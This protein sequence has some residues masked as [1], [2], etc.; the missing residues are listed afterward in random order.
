[1]VQSK[2]RLTKAGDYNLETAE[3]LSYKITG[4][5]P[6]QQQPYRVDI[7]N[8]ILA[9]ELQEG[10]FNH[11]MLG[12]LQVYDTKDVRTLLPIVG[13]ERLN[14]KFSTPG[15]S[16]INATANEGHPFHIYKI[17]SVAPDVKTV[18]SG[19]QVYDIFFCSR[20]SYFN[21]LRKVSK[22]YEGPVEIGVEDI[23]VNKKYLN[24]RKDLYVEP[25]KYLT[26]M[27]MPNVRPFKAIEMLAKKAVS[28]KYQNGGYLFYETKEGYQFRSI[29]SLLAVGGAIA[30]PAKWAYRYQQ[31]N[32]RHHSGVKDIVE[33]MHGVLSWNLIK[34][35]NT[36]NHIEKGGYASKLIE[37][38]MFNKTITETAYD[39]AKDFGNHFHTEH[40]D[41]GKTTVKTPLPKTKFEDTNMSFS[42]EYDQKIML[43]SSTDY[44][45]EMTD[46][47]NAVIADAL[48]GGIPVPLP[49]VSAKNTT[50]KALSQRQLLT[51]GLLE[52]K[53]P[54]NS[55]IQAG[56]IITFDMPIMEPTG[57]NK[58][59]QSSPYW[60]GR[61]LIYDMKHIVNRADDVYHMVLKCVKDNVAKPYVAEHNSWTHYGKGG[62]KTHNLY[63]VDNELLSRIRTSGVLDGEKLPN[64][65][66]HS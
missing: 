60:S 50:Q 42:E 23:F 32:V 18:G 5:A 43:K 17:E 8:I 28:K 40:S 65:G 66:H 64:R 12:R 15:Q 30:R 52:L 3:I 55:L 54:G 57:H 29:E 1:M 21:N 36:L 24:A 31:Q 27:V 35:V 41:G 16:G 20:E 45:H 6:G 19:S 53:V 44:I 4:G 33:D 25:T 47:N 10:I 34:S 2:D 51:S 26:K 11:T 39:Y 13:L 14:L 56:D 62:R 22:A 61:Y 46:S 48:A 59:I 63:E 7:R 49:H 37:H 38:D 9:I 58:T